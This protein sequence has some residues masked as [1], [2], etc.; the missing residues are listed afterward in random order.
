[1]SKFSLKAVVFIAILLAA[2]ALAFGLL[3]KGTPVEVHPV[4]R[5]VAIDAV[6]ATVEVEHASIVTLSGEEGGRIVESQLKVGER[7]EEGDWLVRVGDTDLQLEA[8]A[9]KDRIQYLERR[10]ELRMQKTIELARAEEELANHEKQYAAGNYAE[11]EIKRR[12]REFKAFEENQLRQQLDEEQ[13]LANLRH[14]LERVELRIARCTIDAPATGTVN[15]IFAFEGEVVHPRSQIAQ[16]HSDKLLVTARINEEDFA[17]VQKG[18]DATV[19]LLTYGDRLFNAKVSHVLPG[20]DPETQRYTVFLKLDIPEEMLLPGLSGEA[21]IIRSRKENAL[22]IPRRALF[23]NSV[24]LAV[25]GKAER[26]TVAVGAR[27]LNQVEVTEG[28]AAE[29]SVITTGAAEL[30]D[31]D[32]IRIR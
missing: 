20:A 32:R 13:Q 30:R 1:M 5:G 21:S 19:R 31:G 23:G 27:G 18:L 15:R 26:R 24:F 7:V 17:G 9:L 16:I 8:T 29:D 12:R 6:P 4:E 22:M 2:G 11:L 14:Q 3:F 28:L 10:A 25:D